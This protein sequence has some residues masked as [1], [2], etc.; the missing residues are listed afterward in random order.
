MCLPKRA[1]TTANEWEQK[2]LEEG[3]RLVKCLL[4]RVV[5]MYVQLLGLVYVFTNAFDDDSFQESLDDVRFR[6]DENLGRFITSVGC[7]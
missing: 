2:P 4:Q 3:C 1:Y 5:Q 7:P 6:R